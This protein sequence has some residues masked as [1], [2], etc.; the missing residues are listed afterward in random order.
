MKNREKQ[1]CII[2]HHPNFNTNNRKIFKK[3][4]NGYRNDRSF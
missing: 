4:T 2:F 3:I 1:K